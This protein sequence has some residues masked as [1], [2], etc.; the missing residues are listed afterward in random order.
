LQP[1]RSVEAAFPERSSAEFIYHYG[2][3]KREDRIDMAHWLPAEGLDLYVC[4]RVIPEQGRPFISW[5]GVIPA[6]QLQV[7]GTTVDLSGTTHPAGDQPMTAYGLEYLLERRQVPGAWVRKDDASAKWIGWSPTFN[8]RY[9]SGLQELGNRSAEKI[10]ESGTEVA[11]GFGG[12]SVWSHRDIVEYLLHYSNPDGPS[13]TEP[14]FYLAPVAETEDPEIIRFFDAMQTRVPHEGRNVSS[15]LASLVDRSRGLGAQ[16]R[17]STLPGSGGGEAGFPSGVVEFELVSMADAAISVG[18]VTLPPN[19]MR[20]YLSLDRGLEVQHSLVTVDAMATYDRLRVQGARVLSC[21]SVAT[22]VL[23]ITSDRVLIEPDWLAATQTAYIAA[24]D[25]ARTSP[26]FERVWQRFRLPASFNWRTVYFQALNPSF[27]DNAVIDFASFA[28]YMNTGHSWRRQLPFV[29]P[30]GGADDEPVYMAPFV[31]MRILESG[32]DQYKWMM[33]NRPA[34][35]H[36][37]CQFSLID[38]GL[39]L[40]IRYNPNHYAAKNHFTADSAITAKLDYDQMVATVCLETDT[41]PAVD[42]LLDA[43]GVG[44]DRTLTITVPD[45]EVWIIAQGTVTGVASDGSLSAYRGDRVLRDDTA[46]LRH[47]A[48]LA[49]AVYAKHRRAVNVRY[50]GLRLDHPLGTYIIAAWQDQVRH[51]IESVVTQRVMDY[52]NNSTAIKTGFV[53]LDF[54]KSAG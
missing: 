9:V 49:K 43:P 15:V 40:D 31:L 26:D 51:D 10:Q 38:Q 27:S 44:R 30:G 2:D 42:V 7:F 36:K 6:E 13:I 33:G 34:P 14:D 29:V 50:R 3:V 45:V 25:V 4:I 53:E 35:D 21:F 8:Q 1:L 24:D 54:A 32:D 41:R 39:A 20:E 47:I 5:V 12:S 46:R 52:E 16:V 22:S 48:A 18:D 19:P 11:Y 23:D 37:P 17:W 28:E